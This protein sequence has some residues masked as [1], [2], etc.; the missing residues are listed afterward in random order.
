MLVRLELLFKGK[1][2]LGPVGV[3]EDPNIRIRTYHLN[4]LRYF[5]GIE[6]Q[7]LASLVNVSRELLQV[8]LDETYLAV[9]ALLYLVEDRPKVGV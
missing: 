6:T 2:I 4:S 5:I 1:L 9:I 3:N 8:V 7:I